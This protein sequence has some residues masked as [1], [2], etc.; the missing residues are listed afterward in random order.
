MK[1]TLISISVVIALSAC[2]NQG[3]KLDESL[4]FIETEAC[5]GITASKPGVIYINPKI[6]PYSGFDGFFIIP[7]E[8]VIK[9]NYADDWDLLTIEC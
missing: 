6:W 7:R 3:G 2:G 8:I 4:V 9:S 1:K 5:T